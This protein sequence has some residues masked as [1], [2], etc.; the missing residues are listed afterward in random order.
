M[1]KLRIA[2]DGKFPTYNINLP[3]GG[4]VYNCDLAANTQTTLAVPSG[5][6]LAVFGLSSAN[7]YWVSDTAFTIPVGNTFS[8]AQRALLN[9]PPLDV[10]GVSTLYFR[11]PA[12][13]GVSVAFYA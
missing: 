11:A 9:P 4:D 12:S 2:S 13:C 1:Q 5:A 8:N 10:T 7:D 3:G 6:R